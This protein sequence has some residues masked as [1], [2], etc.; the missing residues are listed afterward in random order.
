VLGDL[1]GRKVGDF[2]WERN[3]GFKTLHELDSLARWAESQDEKAL[4]NGNG[5]LPL[6]GSSALAK[7]TANGTAWPSGISL[8]V[9]VRRIADHETFGECLPLYRVRTLGD[10]H[11]RSVSE[12]LQCKNC[13]WG[14]LTEI[15]QLIE[16]A[17]SGDFD[18]SSINERTAAAELLILLE[19]GMAKLSAQKGSFSSP[20][21]KAYLRRDQRAMG[22][23][24]SAGSSGC[25]RSA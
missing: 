21:S 8:S 3:C 16:R 9:A 25:F 24:P 6:P 1:H 13:G 17:I 12:L 23:Y 10:L 11:G 18:G 2:A 15:Q 22:V 5:T 4:H 20:E 7:A 14:T 19:Q